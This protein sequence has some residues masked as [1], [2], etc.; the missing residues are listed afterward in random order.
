MTE[1]LQFEWDDANRKHVARH[2]VA[3]EEAE[4]AMKNDPLE[5]KGLVRKGEFRKLC[6][7]LTDSGRYLTLVYT[8]RGK[9]IRIVTAYPSHRDHRRIYESQKTSPASSDQNAEVQE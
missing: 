1:G 7:G 4:Q 8:I 2:S 5:L 9:R 6:I 3:P